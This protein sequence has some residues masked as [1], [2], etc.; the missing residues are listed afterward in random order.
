MVAC[1]LRGGVAK[2]P[3]RCHADEG[4]AR[5]QQKIGTCLVKIVPEEGV[6]RDDRQP[7]QAESSRYWRQADGDAEDR[8][9]GEI[10]KTHR[11]LGTAKSLHPP[12]HVE[13]V[14]RHLAVGIRMVHKSKGPLADARVLGDQPSPE[15][16]DPKRSP[17]D[18]DQR[19]QNG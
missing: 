3:H 2:E 16:V 12:E 11:Q 14:E 9:G 1:G 18:R 5:K 10:G 7:N 4:R 13:V 17:I 15:F 8:E 19:H 6:E